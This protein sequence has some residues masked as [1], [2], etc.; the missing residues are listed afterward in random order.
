MEEYH[1]ITTRQS[2]FEKIASRVI[3]CNIVKHGW[4]ISSFGRGEVKKSYEEATFAL[5]VNRRNKPDSKE[6]SKILHHPLDS[7]VELISLFILSC[8]VLLYFSVCV[9]VIDK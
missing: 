3:D 4:H 5:K 1:K 2:A 9:C 6:L 7:I 8:F